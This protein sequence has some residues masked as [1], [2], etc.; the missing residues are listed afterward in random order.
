MKLGRSHFP[1]LDEDGYATVEGVI[2]LND[3]AVLIA[4]IEEHVSASGVAHQA[5][6]RALA[7][8][9]PSVRRMR[10][11]PRLVSV[12]T[13]I[14][15]APAFVVRTLL[16][17][18][19]PDAN[20]KVAWHQDLTIAVAQRQEVP[21]FGP[22]SVKD[23][24]PHVQPPI[25]LLAR[26]IT[27]RLHL[28]DCMAANGALRVIPGTHRLGRLSPVEIAS[29][30]EQSV[31]VTCELAAGGVMVMRPLILHASSPATSPLHR[32]VL[33]LEF[34]AEHVP[35]GLAWAEAKAGG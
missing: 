34:A 29:V 23:G 25:E 8:K 14:L 3:L 35:G 11:H 32:R 33:H 19:T 30:R 16:F 26:M 18:K 10:E 31:D 27:L 5:G 21:G 1:D 13:A 7:G 20:W 22:W 6:L 4:E 15:G 17:D 24:I 28:D 2:P 12:A 9:L